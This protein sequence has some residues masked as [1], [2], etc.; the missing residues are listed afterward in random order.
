[1][2]LLLTVATSQA[3]FPLQFVTSTVVLCRCFHSISAKRTSRRNLVRRHLRELRLLFCVYVFAVI[4]RFLLPPEQNA[5]A[6]LEVNG[7]RDVTSGTAEVRKKSFHCT[8][9]MYV[10][11]DMYFVFVCYIFCLFLQNVGV[12]MTSFNCAI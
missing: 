4:F 11:I 12:S 8:S 3:T 1:M 6:T 10:C 9:R 2:S 5:G 7:S